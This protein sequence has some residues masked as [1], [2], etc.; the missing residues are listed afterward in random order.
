MASFE[1]RF[2]VKRPGLL[3][4]LGRDVRLAWFLAGMVWKNFLIGG[5]VRRRYRACMAKGEPYYVD[6]A[7]AA[8]MAPPKPQAGAPAAEVRQ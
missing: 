6:E 2:C 7:M 8:L 3:P 1:E 5:R 4:R